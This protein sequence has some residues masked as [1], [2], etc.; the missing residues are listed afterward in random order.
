MQ[1]K[2]ALSLE[3]ENIK[4]QEKYLQN[5]IRSRTKAFVTESESNHLSRFAAASIIY[6]G[7][8]QGTMKAA[9]GGRLETK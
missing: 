6:F 5:S 2:E 3:K 9:E 4:A 7:Q 1:Q 8:G